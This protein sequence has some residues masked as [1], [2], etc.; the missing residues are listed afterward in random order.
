MVIH[1]EGAV[2]PTNRTVIP[3]GTTGRIDYH[4]MR[5]R[6]AELDE[7]IAKAICQ[8]HHMGFRTAQFLEGKVRDE[9]LRCGSDHVLL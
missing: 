6:L 4:R 5:K 3:V 9:R 1:M 7:L 8:L 2:M